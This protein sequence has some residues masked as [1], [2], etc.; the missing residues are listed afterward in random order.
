[1]LGLI[2]FL[3]IVFLIAAGFA[4]LA[5]QSG[6]LLLVKLGGFEFAEEN[7][8]IIAAIAFALLLAIILIWIVIAMVWKT[9]NNIGSFFKN[10]RREKGWR[11][12]ANG[13]IAVGAGD[14]NAAKRAAKQS[15]KFLPKE[16]VS[17]LLTAQAAQMEGNQD[18][19][20]HAFETMLK[21]SETKILGLRGLYMEAEASGDT[22]AARLL[23]EEAVNEQP[24]LEWSGK[25]LISMQALEGN[26]DDALKTLDQN[27]NAK[28]YDKNE[29]KRLRAVLLTASAMQLE[30]G[31]PEKA[32]TQ[33]LEAHR[34]APDLVPATTTA[35]RTLARLGDVRKAAKLIQKTWKLMPHP[36]LMEAYSHVRSGDSGLDRLKRAQTLNKLKPDHPEGLMGIARAQIDLQDWDGARETLTRLE[37]GAQTE[38]VCLMMSEIEEGQYG[39][40]GRMREW[41]SRAVR[42]PRDAVWTADGYIADEWAPISPVSSNLDAFQWR[43]PI[44]NLDEGSNLALEDIPVG[45]RE[46]SSGNQ[47]KEASDLPLI[48]EGNTDSDVIIVDAKPAIKPKTKKK[49]QRPTKAKRRNKMASSKPQNKKRGAAATI[50]KKEPAPKSKGT[51]LIDPITKGPIDDPGIPEGEEMAKKRFKLF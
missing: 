50:K 40:R 20:H 44:E 21:K 51:T 27:A 15:Q 24:G 26:W 23:V 14:I 39:D 46:I 6:S 4:W 36:E 34:L 47:N 42:A 19:A 3:I 43:V 10:R 30:T 45:P 2:I 28:L 31:D 13:M 29:A 48:E 16:S 17:G 5:D 18:V 9:P 35:A 12:I 41:L 32:K 38:R 37:Q 1:M 49:A 7:L 11:A 33:A 22:Q 25:A 8:A